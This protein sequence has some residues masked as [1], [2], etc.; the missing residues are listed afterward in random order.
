MAN[1]LRGRLCSE[2]EL[3]LKLKLD[4]SDVNKATHAWHKK[5]HSPSFSSYKLKVIMKYLNKV[6]I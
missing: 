5:S 4:P 3:D 1:L 6:I 2:S